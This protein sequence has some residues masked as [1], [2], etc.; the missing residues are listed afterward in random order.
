MSWTG[1]AS[2][3]AAS[4]Q[5][6]ADPCVFIWVV[7]TGQGLV[8][9][10]VNHE[11]GSPIDCGNSCQGSFFGWQLN[12]VRLTAESVGLSVFRGWTDCPDPRGDQCWVPMDGFNHCVKAQFSQGTEV[13]GSCPPPN[14]PPP[15]IGTGPQ[16]PPPPTGG[17]LP[18]SG[19]RCV[20]VGSPRAD[21]L[22]GTARD[23]RICGMGGEDTIYGGG[24]DDLLNGGAG[25]DRIS[26]QGGRDRLVG[27]VGNDRL[28]G[29]AAN[30]ALVG[31]A[32]RDNLLGDAGNDSLDGGSGVDRFS[33]GA[34][35]DT[36]KARDRARETVNGGPGRDTASADRI[37][38]LRAIERRR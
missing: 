11:N 20:V 4:E 13:A 30:D 16:T 38:R 32:G 37:D 34:G 10:N 33:G 23:D 2:L 17:G 29:S 26:G 22:T 35:N 8:Y 9:S 25:N 15:P 3:I 31:G 24:G 28:A 36:I 14:L 21:V 6:A 27:G 1:E 18:G 19:A 12:E 5:C 7:R